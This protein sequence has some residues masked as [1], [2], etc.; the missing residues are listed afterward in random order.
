MLEVDL[1]VLLARLRRV[2]WRGAKAIYEQAKQIGM[3][4]QQAAKKRANM[5]SGETVATERSN[6]NAG[7]TKVASLYM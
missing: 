3:L 6:L 4:R 2:G 1:Y 5:R 7:G